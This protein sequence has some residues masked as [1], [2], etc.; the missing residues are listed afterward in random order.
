MP[1]YDSIDMYLLGTI[2]LI[3][4]WLFGWVHAEVTRERREFEKDVQRRLARL[5]SRKRF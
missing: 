5:N 1:L 2:C 3:G 4:G